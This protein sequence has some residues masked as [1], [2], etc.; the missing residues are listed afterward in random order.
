MREPNPIPR[1]GPDAM[2]RCMNHP[3]LVAAALQIAGITSWSDSVG[4]MKDTPLLRV[5]PIAD[6]EVPLIGNPHAIVWSEVEEI[7][8]GNASFGMCEDCAYKFWQAFGFPPLYV[9]QHAIFSSHVTISKSEVGMSIEPHTFALMRLETE[10]GLSNKVELNCPEC[11]V[12]RY[13]EPTLLSI[14]EY[15]YE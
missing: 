7:Y 14:T 6:F 12:K 13:K 5:A 15:N 4:L 9:N 1:I 10:T 8:R 11:I 3:E 2:I